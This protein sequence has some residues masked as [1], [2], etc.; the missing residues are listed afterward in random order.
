[1]TK[2]RIALVG[3]AGS[4][5][6]APYDD[7]T[8]EIWG[9]SARASY[10]T[11]AD[12]WFELH[13][14]DGEPPGWANNWRQTIKGFSSDLQMV[15]LY[16]EFD[17]GPNVVQYPA[18]KIIARFGTFFMTSSFAWMTALAIDEMVP[19][20][21][22]AAPD[23]CEIGIWGVDMEHGTE[24]RQQRAGFRHFIAVAHLL[25]IEVTRL[26]TGG[27]SYD[28]IPYPLWQ[29]DPLQNKLTL[30]SRT[31]RQTLAT[32][33]DSMRM[34]REM[35]TGNKAALQEIDMMAAED[36][37]P[38]KRRSMLVKQIG[39]LM[40]TSANISH[41]IVKHEAMWEEHSWMLDYLAP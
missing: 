23:T 37:D 29:D 34:T 30:R 16:P 38:E 9:V 27:L 19:D 35:I 41:D 25:G 7:P 10:V 32:L 17:L 21:M 3:T 28:P 18:E 6:H 39:G 4:G 24:Y 14:L 20:G 2:R 1:M 5:E 40:D 8:W 31:T 26:A 15:M 11:R 33:E 13:R 12:R 22:T 36:Y